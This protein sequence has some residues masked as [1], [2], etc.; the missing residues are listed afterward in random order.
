M[1]ISLKLFEHI[2][3]YLSLSHSFGQLFFNYLNIWYRDHLTAPRSIPPES[4]WTWKNKLVSIS[5]SH[6]L[7]VPVS[8]YIPLVR[9]W[10]LLY[11]LVT[12]YLFGFLPI[13]EAPKNAD[14]QSRR[15]SNHLQQLDK[16]FVIY[17]ENRRSGTVIRHKQVPVLSS[18][19]KLRFNIYA[20]MWV[21]H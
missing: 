1:V 10:K 7:P 8:Q 15:G 21:K 19:W 12:I 16:R 20:L 9:G 3:T 13:R 5:S 2:W 6:Q 11:W 17:Q 18:L 14:F 4:P